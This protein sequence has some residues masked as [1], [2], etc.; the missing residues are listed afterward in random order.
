MSTTGEDGVVAAAAG[1]AA[2]ATLA[3]SGSANDANGTDGPVGSASVRRD[4][5]AFAAAA[6]PAGLLLM[7]PSAERFLELRVATPIGTGGA[8][9]TDADVEALR[10]G[11]LMDRCGRTR[12]A[13]KQTAGVGALEGMADQQ[14][15]E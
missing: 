12:A 8:T 7:S 11:K 5:V 14:Q 15:P 10:M 3:S 1:L 9:E 4:L 13:S 6:A 2:T